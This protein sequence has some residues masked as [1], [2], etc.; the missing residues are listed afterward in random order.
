[1]LRDGA[2]LGDLSPWP[3]PSPRGLL[4]EAVR[5]GVRSVLVLDLARIGTGEG[6]GT[7]ELCAWTRRTFPHLE[8]LAGGGIRDRADLDRLA[9]LGVDG[10]LVG[11]ALHDGRLP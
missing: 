6:T 8:I 7:E 2:P 4:S 9:S 5:R 3:D 10:A 1:D 11:A